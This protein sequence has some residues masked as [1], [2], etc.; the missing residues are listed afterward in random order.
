MDECEVDSRD[1]LIKTFQVLLS[2]SKKTLHVF[3]SSRPDRDIQNLL[4]SLPNI[5]IQ[6]RHNER[7]IQL[8]IDEKIRKYRARVDI[9]P[10]LKD[11]ITEVLLARSQG[12]FLWVSLQIEQLLELVSEQAIR[13]RLGKLPIGLKKTYDEIYQKI[14]NRHKHDRSLADRAIMWVM[15]T[16]RPMK[17]EELL[18]AIRL[19]PENSHSDWLESSITKNGLLSLCNNLLV[20]DSQLRVWRFAH[21]S[22]AEYFENSHLEL[23]TSHAFV[24]K[25]CLKL[26]LGSWTL[27][28]RKRT[29]D[30]I[31][32]GNGRSDESDGDDFN[33]PPQDFL[34]L[35]SVYNW[36]RH[37]QAQEGQYF[38]AQL[39]NL[40]KRFL[41]SFE[42]SSEHYRRWHERVRGVKTLRPPTYILTRLDKPSIRKGDISPGDT[43]LWAV[44]RF[45][46]YSLLKDWWASSQAIPSQ[47][48]DN[49]DSLLILAAAGGSLQICKRLVGRGIP[50]NATSEFYGSALG[51]A[52]YRNYFEIVRFLVQ[53]GADINMSFYKCRMYQSALIA[54][55]NGGNL[56]VVELLV[57]Q[58]A[59]VNMEIPYKNPLTRGTPRLLSS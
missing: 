2:E 30:D 48:N 38:D 37:V 7:D 6:A 31:D 13:D 12:M 52:A 54:A 11:N 10:T 45:S 23:P 1:E 33:N 51:I 20:F 39:A 55:I 19:N 42:E 17:K 3:I 59:D 56:K 26:L 25:V 27:N 53:E 36:I 57:Q 18:F 22:V 15:C 24:A 47:S 4:C 43:P 40:L 21:L 46:I 28:S 32:D 9:T 41:G 14:E 29:Y 58:G 8:F 49:G 35:Y 16:N 5:E 34:R 44:C 50:I